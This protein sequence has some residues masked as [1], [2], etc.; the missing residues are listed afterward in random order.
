VIFIWIV[1]MVVIDV[2]R[3]HDISGWAKAAWVVFVVVLPWIG[4]LVYL[5]ANHSGMNERRVNESAQAEAEF[6]N[7]VRETAGAGGCGQRD[8]EGQAAARQR[9]VTQ[10]EFDSIKARRSDKTGARG[11]SAALARDLSSAASSD[12][13]DERAG[14]PSPEE[15]DVDSLLVRQ[16]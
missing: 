14:V 9:P 7:Y 11:D 3:R 2:F 10:A 16:N 1:I 15:D 6:D 12:H 4:A 13:L 8:R 5:I